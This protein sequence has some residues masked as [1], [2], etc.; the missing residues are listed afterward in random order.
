MG[1]DDDNG[2]P[3]MLAFEF[4]GSDDDRIGRAASPPKPA[5]A[6]TASHRVRPG[7]RAA[8]HILKTFGVLI[9]LMIGMLVLRLL[10]FSA[11]GIMH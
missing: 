2:V 7:A 11:C 8:V 10:L 1:S 5:T 6:I 4:A 3:H 9:L